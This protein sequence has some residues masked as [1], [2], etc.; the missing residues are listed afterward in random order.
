M[1]WLSGASE[2]AAENTLMNNHDVKIS[3]FI[4]KY[5]MVGIC[6]GDDEAKQDMTPV[7]I[8]IATP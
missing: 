3:D 2:D 5:A 4:V 8:Q 6:T 7:M 1:R